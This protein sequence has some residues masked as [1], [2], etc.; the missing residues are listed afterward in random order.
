MVITLI[1]EYEA[2]PG[3]SGL[4]AVLT[5]LRVQLYLGVIYYRERRPNRVR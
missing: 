5:G 2:V 3:F 1:W 4:L